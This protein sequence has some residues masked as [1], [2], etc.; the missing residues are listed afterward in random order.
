MKAMRSGAPVAVVACPKTLFPASAAKADDRKDA[1]AGSAIDTPTPRK[2][3][4]RLIAAERWSLSNRFIL[5][6]FAGEG[7]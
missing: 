2:K 7:H 3:W 4:R 5:R 1:K 6:S